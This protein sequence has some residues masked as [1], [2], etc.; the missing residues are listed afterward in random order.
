[1]IQLWNITKFPP[2]SKNALAFYVTTSYLNTL[3]IIRGWRTHRVNGQ[4]EGLANPHEVVKENIA[5]EMNF[6]GSIRVSLTKKKEEED[7]TTYGNYSE[8]SLRS[9]KRWLISFCGLEDIDIITQLKWYG[10]MGILPPSP[11]PLETTLVVSVCKYDLIYIHPK[12][13]SYQNRTFHTR[14]KRQNSHKL[15][16]K[17]VV[18]QKN[19]PRSLSLPRASVQLQDLATCFHS[20]RWQKGLSAMWNLLKGGGLPDR[21]QEGCLNLLS[22]GMVCNPFRLV[23]VM[24]L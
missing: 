4:E 1:M 11:S 6:K 22:G 3:C 5:E 8:E 14:D 13:H 2:A 19:S 21:D 10:S 9:F 17:R 15:C 16:A 7:S 20:S 23:S 18:F 12:W 24:P